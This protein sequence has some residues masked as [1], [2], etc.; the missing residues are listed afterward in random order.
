MLLDLFKSDTT[1]RPWF[2]VV[3]A[4]PPK[5]PAPTSVLN[6][7]GF[8]ATVAPGGIATIFGSDLASD[9]APATALPLP[10]GL[11]GTTVDI[12]GQP[13]PLYFVS[14]TQIN[15]VVP[16]LLLVN[17]YLRAQNG[18]VDR[19]FIDLNIDVVR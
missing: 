10:Y 15:F 17:E 3:P 16:T 19:A 2:A 13:A 18:P 6:A 1:T 9:V 5:T 8:F 11:N 4:Q 14:P 12:G 7:A